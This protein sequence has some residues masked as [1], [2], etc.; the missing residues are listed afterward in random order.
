MFRLTVR[1]FYQSIFN[2][3]VS[4]LCRYAFIAL[5][6]MPLCSYVEIISGEI[7]MLPTNRT[8]LFVRK[9]IYLKLLA[10]TV[11]FGFHV[12]FG[13]HFIQL[14]QKKKQFL[15]ARKNS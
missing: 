1:H 8:F 13:C 11:C 2:G 12:C 10:K 14:R 9:R 6:V 7:A 15:C 4:L 3:N 5:I